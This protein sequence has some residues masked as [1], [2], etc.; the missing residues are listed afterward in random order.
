MKSEDK[1]QENKSE[2][3]EEKRRRRKKRRKKKRRKKKEKD[4]TDITKKERKMHD[5]FLTGYITDPER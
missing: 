2:E 1:N 4:I 5:T 3:N